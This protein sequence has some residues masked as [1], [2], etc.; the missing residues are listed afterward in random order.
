MT[1]LFSRL[2]ADA[3]AWSITFAVMSLLA[4]LLAT[5]G[6]MSYQRPSAS[7]ENYSVDQ[8]TWEALKDRSR[9]RPSQTTTSTTTSK[10]CKRSKSHVCSGNANQ[11]QAKAI[12]PVV[13]TVI[14]VHVVMDPDPRATAVSLGLFFTGVLT[15]IATCLTAFFQ[16]AEHRRKQDLHKWEVIDKQWKV[17]DGNED[18]AA[19]RAARD[20]RPARERCR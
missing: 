15:S 12:A 14:T 10:N 13:P 17:I 5:F 8:K 18:R 11:Q 20:S 4:G 2:F 7:N 16:F 6:W 19:K 3:K 1:F 9:D